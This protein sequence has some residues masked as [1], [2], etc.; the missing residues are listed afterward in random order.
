MWQVVRSLVEY[1]YLG[2]ISLQVR[3]KTQFEIEDW[4]PQTALLDAFLKL[5][6]SLQL[7][8]LKANTGP[9]ADSEQ[10]RQTNKIENRQK[11]NSDTRFI[12]DQEKQIDVPANDDYR[13]QPNKVDSEIGLVTGLKQEASQFKKENQIASIRNNANA[14][15]SRYEK[16][17]KNLESSMQALFKCDQCES[18]FQRENLLEIH[19]SC[20]HGDHPPS[21]PRKTRKRRSDS[22]PF[23]TQW[24][25][26]WPAAFK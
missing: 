8:E 15:A 1:C 12:S 10:Q 13:K 3:K 9:E 14:K 6:E 21:P 26:F 23:P 17:G 22:R 11:R 16:F 2:R 19:K 5:G 25:T 24:S 20:R 7:C 18:K 4:N